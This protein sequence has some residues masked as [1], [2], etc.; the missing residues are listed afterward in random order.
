MENN[1]S[2][3]KQIS[4]Q[5]HLIGKELNKLQIKTPFI[6]FNPKSLIKKN[7]DLI[8]KHIPSF[9]E[10]IQQQKDIT[11]NLEMINFI[12]DISIKS[13]MISRCFYIYLQFI[14]QFVF[15]FVVLYFILF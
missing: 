2:I 10:K 5:A 14:L 7:E 11:Y 15:S 3:N 13:V 12:T 1:N 8:D 6:I 9:I 4:K